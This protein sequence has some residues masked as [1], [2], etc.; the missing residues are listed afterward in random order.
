MDMDNKYKIVIKWL[1]E[2]ENGKTRF[3]ILQDL[4]EG[5]GAQENIKTFQEMGNSTLTSKE[6]ANILNLRFN[7]IHTY[8]EIVGK[9]PNFD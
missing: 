9:V 5:E 1:Q 6:I 4:K 7:E 2:K 8:L 3:E